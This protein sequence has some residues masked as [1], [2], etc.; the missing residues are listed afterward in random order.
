MKPGDVI[1][2]YR[3]LDQLGEG[4]MGVVFKAEDERLKRTVAL[5]FLPSQQ[6]LS[7]EDRERFAREAQA[8]AALDHSNI[9]TVYEIDEA[10][11]R[12]FMAMAFVEGRSVDQRIAEGP[13]PLGEAAELAR[14]TA[15][16]LRAAHERGVVHRDVKSSNLMITGPPSRPQVKILDFGLA[17]LSGRSKITQA[18]NVLGTIAYMSPEQTQGDPLDK[19]TD[20]WSLGVVLYE[21]VAGELPFKGHYDQATMYSILNEDPEPLTA[22]RSRL[23]VELDWIVDKCLAKNPDERYQSMDDL[24]LDLTTLQK[25]LD[26][27]KLSIHRSQVAAI[28]KP[29]EKPTPAD[30]R[31]T[32][33]VPQAAVE[34]PASDDSK[35]RIRALSI[36]VA[37]LALLAAGALVWALSQRSDAP[38]ETAVAERRVRR[39]DVNLPRTLDPGVQLRQ[40]AISPDGRRLAFLTTQD[41]GRL[42]V[43]DLSQA[44]AWSLEGTD[45]ATHLFWSPDGE[46]LGYHADHEIRKVD[47][48]GGP[49]TTLASLPGDFFGGGDW[50]PSGD[51]LVFISGPPLQVYEL[52]ALG[53]APKPAGDVRDLGAR[54]A[55]GVLQIVE[56]PSGDRFILTETRTPEGSQMLAVNLDA[57]GAEPVPIGPGSAPFYAPSGHLFYQPSRTS[58]IWAQP[59]SLERMEPLA[60][61]FP[62]AQGGRN[63]SVSADGTLAY[64]DDALTGGARRL[65]WRDRSGELVSEVG[66]A[67]V[68]LRGPRVSPDGKNVAVVAVDAGGADVWLHLDGSSSNR[69]I[70]LH[71][72]DDAWP[73]W[74]PDGTRI[75]FASS[76]AGRPAL[77]QRAADGSG[78][79]E[80][81]FESDEFLTPLDWSGDRILVRIR[82]RRASGY[83]V[84]A[85]DG[86]GR[87]AMER[88]EG[89]NGPT[90]DARLSPDARHIVFESRGRGPGNILVQ[91]VGADTAPVPI[92]P[93]GGESPVW[94]GDPREVY[95]VRGDILYSVRLNLSDGIRAAEPEPLFG[96]PA[97]SGGFRSP[98]YDVSPDGQRFAVVE[99]VGAPPAPTI[100]IVLDWLAEFQR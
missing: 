48:R 30:E 81:L 9:C 11:G 2:H 60:D 68:G 8:A 47:A 51:S 19:R 74:S 13:L 77:F 84:L 90:G 16:G 52:S 66:V 99:M 75:V 12:P 21:M 63:P 24:L 54:R 70:T 85:P 17:Q 26:S 65:V 22:L 57:D 62:V 37:A 1:S 31:T 6:G 87:Y 93:E 59:F 97:L 41:N 39:F 64:V 18:D 89:V 91:R 61:A 78:D 28:E 80:L 38:A 50:S 32:R 40:L 92:S 88:L 44:V 23:P 67:Q 71:D 7:A 83:G 10:Q 82:S 34:A 15:E 4:G 79:A 96:H 56:S 58:E 73:V 76:R 72:G 46:T 55:G 5:K 45:G 27:Q 29:I 100:R 25:K 36:A 95:F 49:S 3:I 94:G 69:R 35:A 86:E 98:G 14:Q 43:R 33:A 53:G 20:V 42:W